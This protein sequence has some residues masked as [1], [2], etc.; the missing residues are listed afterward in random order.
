MR[1]GLGTDVHQLVEGRRLIIGGVEVPYSKGLLGHSDADVLIHAVMDALL[2][3]LCLGDIGVLFPDHDPQYKD[4]DSRI[5]LRCVKKKID[6]KNFELGNLDCVI[7]CQAPKL[8]PFIEKMQKTLAEDLRC[9]Y[10]RISIKATTTE[11]LGFVGR[12]E[13]IHAQ[14]VCL[15]IEKE[16]KKENNA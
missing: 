2:G 15:L 5:L 3:A 1:I 6:E 10:D 12:Q 14:A 4:I 7:S 9:T 13:G 11:H 8:R 16:D